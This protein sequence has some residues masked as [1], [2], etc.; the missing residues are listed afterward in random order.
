M[1]ALIQ[2]VTEAGV[3]VGG[4]LVGSIGKG[5]LVFL[6]VEKGDAAPDIDFT[7][8]KIVNLRIFADDDGKM[9]LSVKD[10]KGEILA[11]SQ[12]TLAGDCRKG[13]RPS[14]DAAEEP[15]RANGVYQA[16]VEK[17]MAEGLKVETGEFSAMM[18]V[19]LVNDGPVTF[20][21][22]SRK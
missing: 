20:M 4:R 8:R 18:Q 13:N 7:V 1:K 21:L 17:L 14:F 9:N 11:V 19:R 2:R 15:G 16:V 5:L 3:E 22:D 12:F 6:G 10:I